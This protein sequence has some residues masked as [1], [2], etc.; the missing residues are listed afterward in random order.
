MICDRADRRDRLASAFVSGSELERPMQF[1]QI[2]RIAPCP[3]PGVGL[4]RG[5]NRLFG[6][7]PP[8]N[9][10]VL[11]TLSSS[12]FDPNRTNAKGPT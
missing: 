12:G 10:L 6:R 11:L 5:L 4:A 7:Y 8:K 3:N 1:R 9:G 2:T